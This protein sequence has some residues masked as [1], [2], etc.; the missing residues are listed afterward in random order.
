[1]AAAE[2]W[3]AIKERILSGAPDAARLYA[4]VHSLADTPP[5][6]M[7]PGGYDFGAVETNGLTAACAAFAAFVEDDETYAQKAIALTSELYFNLWELPPEDWDRGTINGGQALAT[8]SVAY[9]LLVGLG[10]ADEAEAA[11]MREAVRTF[12]RHLYDCYVAFPILIGLPNNHQIKL[13]AAFGVAGMTF[14]DTR[15]AATYVNLAQS[16]APYF[17]L[18]FQMPDGGGQAEGPTYLDYSFQTFLYYA[19]A[20]HRFAQ[21][22][23]YPCKIICRTRLWP[24]CRSE[25]IEV[26][27]PAADPRLAELLDWRLALIMPNGYAPPIDDS[28]LGCGNF[29][30]VAALFERADYAWHYRTSPSCKENTHSL[31]L[32]ELSALDR[33]PDPVE[34]SGGPS[35]FWPEAGQ[36]VLRTSWQPDALYALLIGEHGKAR[37][38]GIGHEQPDATSFLLYAR[39]T[40]FAL[41][42]GY[43]SYRE[44]HHTANAAN[45]SLIL[46][47]EA[48][49]RGPTL[50][51]A[52]ADAYLSEFVNEPLFRSARVDSR[53]ENA[54]V[55]RRLALVGDDYFVTDDAIVS[56]EPRD[57]AWLLHT[58]AG[59]T[60]NGVFRRAA[61]GATVNRPEGVMRVYVQSDSDELELDQQIAE[62]ALSHSALDRHMVLRGE[63]TAPAARFFAVYLIG[64]TEATLP[65]AERGEADNPLAWIVASDE[66]VDATLSNAGGDFVFG[67][68]PSFPGR[69]ESDGELVWMRTE[70]E[71]GALV[72]SQQIGGTYFNYLPPAE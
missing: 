23:A 72:A 6:T 55:R 24:P 48:G 50:V 60:T 15:E 34:P 30:P 27:D 21:G 9:D 38:S 28:N 26:E 45:H 39:G 64:A 22:E 49:P 42:S 62:H 41:D 7:P 58:N 52:D 66:Y 59:G 14:N 70:P 37:R 3:A 19:A 61:Y 68:T 1:L 63:L 69:V 35:V 54:D 31:A 43:G 65:V 56:D 29:G 10:F 12:A 33:M 32:I 17:L 53:Y 36:A 18:D 16:S 4:R 44:R 51:F 47:D 71:T 5:R 57:Y 11:A 20:Y 8:F 40:M 25:V 2:P 67:P 13:T 46:V